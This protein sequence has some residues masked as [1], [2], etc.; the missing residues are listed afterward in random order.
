MLNPAGLTARRVIFFLQVV[1][2]TETE[3]SG[4]RDTVDFTF[5]IVICNKILT[6]RHYKILNFTINYLQ[7]FPLLD[8]PIKSLSS[9][10]NKVNHPSPDK[11]RGK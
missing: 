10:Q 4:I 5:Y 8:F 11:T 1:A 2:M 9:N 6:G 3:E 7:Y